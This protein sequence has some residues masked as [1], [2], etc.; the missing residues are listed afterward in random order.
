MTP[1]IP[2]GT[3]TGYKH[4]RCR[5]LDCCN[6]AAA[7]QRRRYRR[8]G[9]GIWQPLV[10]TGAARAHMA[11]LYEQ[12]MAYEQIALASG[13]PRNTLDRIRQAGVQTPIWRIRPETEA[14][15]LA[16][17]YNVEAVT[18]KAH[19][20]SHG[21]VRR[22]RALR[23]QGW[24]LHAIADRAGVD[25]RTLVAIA[26]QQVV[27]AATH[28]AVAL[29]Y[30]DLR[31]LDPVAHGIRPWVAD[32]TRREAAAADMAPPSAWKDIDHDAHPKPRERWAVRFTA[33]RSS[34]TRQEL[35]DETLT[36]ALAGASRA[37]IAAGLGVS[38]DA[39][40]QA[41]RRAQQPLPIRLRVEALEA[42]G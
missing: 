14:R 18:E 29:V 16:V 15:I 39:I 28:L 5:C 1:K 33:E 19:T 10:D 35:I 7:Y 23:A 3:N 2:H 6:A 34:Y 40:T 11:A 27:Y 26:K 41:H 12:G 21:T 31:E 20:P 36:L 30:D 32:R 22:I 9:A 38:W 25:S 17:R 37:E 8:I 4:H 13:L 42:A 24:P